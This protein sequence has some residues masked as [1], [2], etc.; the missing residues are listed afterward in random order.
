MDESVTD[1]G[2]WTFFMDLYLKKLKGAC[3]EKGTELILYSSPAPL[4]FSMRSHNI[5]KKA[6]ERAEVTYIDFNMLQEEI[7]INWSIDTWMAGI[8]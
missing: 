8:I 4:N 3:E 1:E 2:D 6:C 7:G 5:L